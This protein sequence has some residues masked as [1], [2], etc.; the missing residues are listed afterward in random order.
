VN[1]P[2]PEEQITALED[3]MAEAVPSSSSDRVVCK[4]AFSCSGLQLES[5]LE[6]KGAV[7]EALKRSTSIEK[8][9]IALWYP[10]TPAWP[11]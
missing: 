1:V 9:C 8:C 2:T 3:T 11:K 4:T 5:K 7:D 6:F 10:S